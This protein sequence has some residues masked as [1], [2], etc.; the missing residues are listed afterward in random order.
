MGTQKSSNFNCLKMSDSESNDEFPQLLPDNIVLRDWQ[1]RVVNWAM[2][3]REKDKPNGLWMNLPTG[4]GKTVVLRALFDLVRPNDAYILPIC[5]NGSYD[6]RSMIPYKGQKLILIDQ[7]DGERN[8]NGKILWK[9]SLL[10]LLK[11]ITEDS[12]MSVGKHTVYP[13]SKV[14]ITSNFTRPRQDP[15]GTGCQFARRYLS[16]DDLS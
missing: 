1:K 3:P 12:P 16:I 6:T 10:E 15:D 7:V 9:R 14:L 13:K 11:R 2:S 4:C 8:L 5:S